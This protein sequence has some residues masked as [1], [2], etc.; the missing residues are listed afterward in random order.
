MVLDRK[1]GSDIAAI[2][3]GSELVSPIQ[4]IDFEVLCPV[5]RP[6]ISCLGDP[7]AEEVYL[8]SK[9]IAEA[10]GEIPG[11]VLVEH[12]LLRRDTET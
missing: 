11:L 4:F 12:K 6:F 7:G 2:E 9:A 8:V 3:R 5:I 10:L 1:W